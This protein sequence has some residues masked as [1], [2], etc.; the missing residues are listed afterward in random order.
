MQSPLVRGAYPK[1]HYV[2]SED[3]PVKRWI[4]KKQSWLSLKVWQLLIPN[5]EI[6]PFAF[7]ALDLPQTD[8]AGLYFTP[9]TPPCRSSIGLRYPRTAYFN[10]LVIF[11]KI[12]FPVKRKTFLQPTIR[13]TWV[14]CNCTLLLRK[15][16][17][18]RVRFYQSSGQ[19]FKSLFPKQ[20]INVVMFIEEAASDQTEA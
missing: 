14:G 3:P 6:C 11:L 20:R 18:S 10:L 16:M 5:S 7:S 13:P 1:V 9:E 17:F 15:S 8:A 4:L 19:V 2:P 12:M